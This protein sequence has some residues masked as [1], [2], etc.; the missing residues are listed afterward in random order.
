ML[1]TESSIIHKF[2][3]CEFDLEKALTADRSPPFLTD[4]Y[5]DVDCKGL[6]SAW[7]LGEHRAAFAAMHPDRSLV[8]TP[9]VVATAPSGLAACRTCGDKIAKGAVRVGIAAEDSRGDWGAIARW[10]HASCAGRDLRGWLDVEGEGAQERTV[11]RGPVILKLLQ[12]EGFEPK[13]K[14]RKKHPKEES[15]AITPYEEASAHVMKTCVLKLYIGLRDRL[16][17]F[18][19]LE[20]IGK[21]E[22]MAAIMGPEPEVEQPLSTLLVKEEVPA[23]LPTPAAMVTRLLPFQEEGLAWMR[24][25]EASS[26]RGGVLADEMGMGKTIQTIALLMTNRLPLAESSPLQRLAEV[27]AKWEDLDDED[28]PKQDTEAPTC[29]NTPESR[30]DQDDIQPKQEVDETGV[31][32]E[33]P[34]FPWPPDLSNAEQKL[35][36]PCATLIVAPLAAVMQ[37]KTEIE[38]FSLPDTFRILIYHGPLRFNLLDE[39]SKADIIITTYST[40]EVDYRVCVDR[41]KAQCVYCGRKFFPDKLWVH[42][43]YFCGPE[44]ERTQKQKL[45]KRKATATAVT[46]LTGETVDLGGDSDTEVARTPTI[47]NTLK[48]IIKDA[49]RPLEEARIPWFRGSKV[50]P[51]EEEGDKARVEALSATLP[52]DLN[53]LTCSELKSALME[54]KSAVTGRKATLVQRLE[55][56]LGR[57]SDVCEIVL[58]QG[59]A[60]SSKKKG[61]KGKQE[62]SPDTTEASEV[63][64]WQ[65]VDMRDSP[66]HTK[67]WGRVVLDEA[68]HIKSKTASRTKAIYALPCRGTRWC[69]SGTPIQNRVGELQSLLRFLRFDPFGYY[70]CSYAGCS[71]KLIEWQIGK[72][73]KCSTCHHTL[74][75]HYS[76]FNKTVANPIKNLGYVGAGRQAFDILKNDVLRKILLRRTK[77]ERKADLEL[78]PLEVVIRRDELSEEE[79]DF[80][81][82]LYRQSEIQFNTYADSGTILHNYA[83]I[84]D[85]LI[86][87]RQAVNHPY[88][89]VH[90]NSIVGP[91]GVQGSQIPSSSRLMGGVGVCTI[92]LESVA[93]QAAYAKDCDHV[94]HQ[95]CVQEYLT[96]FP[97]QGPACCPACMIPLTVDFSATS[98]PEKC[99]TKASSILSKIDTGLFQSSTKIEALLQEMDLALSSDPESKFLVFS[100]WGAWVGR[101]T[102]S[103]ASWRLLSGACGKLALIVVAWWALCRCR[104]G[105]ISLRGSMQTASSRCC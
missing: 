10:R 95:S 16:L 73:K 50:A 7:V 70:F 12:N 22:V 25:Q 28:P 90:A 101:D 48:A 23:R 5:V 35:L 26:T 42:Q 102:G 45:T 46:N 83:H 40:I 36:A 31:G 81:Q 53:S 67:V 49:G 3:M 69:L 65:G 1:A 85:L 52:P 54:A 20:P 84:F 27:E 104:R 74:P 24:A 44:A 72:D 78:Q 56:I 76:Y 88:L 19:D 98:E 87:L 68:H 63:A 29:P 13:T 105:L 11:F 55:K 37:W 64:E 91:N 34:P 80:Y 32:E 77:E 89:I 15:A 17:G 92:C 33:L 51:E 18:K 61:K 14:R 86:R 4:V 2:Q 43:K 79:Q 39:L 38:R 103:L 47:A 59:V 82:A 62:P 41:Q 75:K 99:S 58:S 94:F 8:L 60:S 21:A 97:G 6:G 71:C 100:Q 66:L 9:V 57:E 93:S 30:V 96:S